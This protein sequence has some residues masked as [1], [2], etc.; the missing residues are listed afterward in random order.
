MQKSSS[1]RFSLYGF[2]LPKTSVLNW[3]ERGS[4]EAGRKSQQP[5]A[6]TRA[7]SCNKNSRTNDYACTGSTS[8]YTEKSF[9]ERASIIRSTEFQKQVRRLWWSTMGSAAVNAGYVSAVF[10][11]GAIDFSSLGKKKQ[12]PA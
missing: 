7:S 1:H 11:I 9:V 3:E 2:Y 12:R 6:A 10:N 5:P 4:G 8:L